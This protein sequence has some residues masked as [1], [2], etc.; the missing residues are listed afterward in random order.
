[1]LRRAGLLGLLLLLV[2]APLARAAVGFQHFTIPDPAGPPIEVGVW[3]PTDAAPQPTRLELFTDP[4]A[5]DAP[6]EGRGL[7][8]VV[9]SHG[10]GGSYAGH[11]DTAYALAEAG[12]VAAA[13]THTGDNWRDQSRA[14]DS[15]ERSRQLKVLTSYMLADWRDHDRIDPAKVGAFGFSSGGFT[16]LVAA[17]GEPDLATIA[18]HCQAHP[19]FYDCRLIARHPPNRPAELAWTHDPRIKAVV[20]V[21]PA[22]G[23][24]F[25]ARGLAGV[26]QPLQLWRAEDDHILP[27]PFYAEAVRTAL[28]VPPEFHVVHGADHYDFLAPC[29]PELARVNRE[30]C[31]SPAGFDRTA[32]HADFNRE[33]V[34]FF[35]RTLGAGS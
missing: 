19:D 17:G 27:H 4:L 25:D 10:N 31:T 29:S 12:F 3:Y 6:V 9:I 33:V 22:V 1:M 35:R 15:W 8:L 21:A 26:R 32:F 28:P 20:A 7:P 5:T 11:H 18:P 34:G 24:A 14:T 30:I 23:F 16:V 2:T 13:L